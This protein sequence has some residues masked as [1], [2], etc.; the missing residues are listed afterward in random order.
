MTTIQDLYEMTQAEKAA[1][2]DRYTLL[3]QQ[4]DANEREI[5]ARYTRR[6]DIQGQIEQHYRTTQARVG[7]VAEPCGMCSFEQC[8][9]ER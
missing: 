3:K 4:Y 8:V 7:Q 1:A 6:Y 5:E 9:C 2:W